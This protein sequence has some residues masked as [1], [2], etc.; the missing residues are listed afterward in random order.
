MGSADKGGPERCE[1]VSEGESKLEK[2]QDREERKLNREKGERKSGK[3]KN[4]KMQM[5]M[6]KLNDNA[7]VKESRV[8]FFLQRK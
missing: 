5:T 1:D 8:D 6:R 3:K 2:K 7:N 4:R